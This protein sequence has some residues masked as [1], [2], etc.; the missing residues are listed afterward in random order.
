MNKKVSLKANID[1]KEDYSQL[2][3]DF[4]LLNKTILVPLGILAENIQVEKES[5]FSPL[6]LLETFRSYFAII[7][8]TIGE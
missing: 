8:T 6:N 4:T 2:H 5:H 7:P 3:Q 1:L